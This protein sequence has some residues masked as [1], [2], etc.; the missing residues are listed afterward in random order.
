MP[1]NPLISQG[2]LNRLVASVQWPNFPALN[3]T[4]PYLGPEG[5]RLALEGESTLFL[6]T[7]TGAVVSPEPYMMMTLTIHLLKS[8]PLASFYKAQM[9]SS[10]LIG[11]GV[12]RPDVATTTLPAYD[13]TNAAIEAV[14]ALD[15]SGRSANFMIRC[16]GYYILNSALWP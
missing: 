9:E 6:Q 5:I 2:V 11:D 4:A 8:Q 7:M 15:F 14:E 3:V 10:T 16:R 12:I 13:I 1:G